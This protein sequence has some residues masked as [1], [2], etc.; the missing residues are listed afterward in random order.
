[1]KYFI[2]FVSTLFLIAASVFCAD[3]APLSFYTEPALF[4]FNAVVG[5]AEDSHDSLYFATHAGLIKYNGISSEKYEHI[6]FDTSTMRS[7]QIQ[8][9][10][11]DA[12][13]ILW[14]GTYSGLERF[15]IK[16][17]TISHAPVTDNVVTA[18][19]RDS[20]RNLW[21]GTING[22]YLCRDDS[23]NNL[24][25]FNNRQ[26]HS[27][28]GNN[29]IRSI[30]EDSHGIIYASTYNGVWQY[31][32][33]EKSFEPCTL[34]PEGCPGKQGLC[35]T[36]LKTLMAYTGFPCGGQDLS[37]L[38][39]AQTRM[40]FIPCRMHGFIRFIIILLPTS[41]LPQVHG[42]AVY[43]SSIKKQKK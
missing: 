20:Q 3:R 16:N 37:A 10:Y 18:I 19:F 5:I 29:T 31:N 6:P 1:M 13:D 25:A 23:Y 8:T 30:S 4:P 21:V 38:R 12:D 26:Y 17:R 22:L 43:T 11:M 28:I 40:T 24:I 32:E 36:L 41:T 2:T 33:S 35:I 7:S 9:I 34:I 42:E 27:F 15:D 39:H 14:V